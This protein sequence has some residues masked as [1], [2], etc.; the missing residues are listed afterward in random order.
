MRRFKEARRVSITLFWFLFEFWFSPSF[1]LVHNREIALGWPAWTPLCSTPAASR[2]RSDRR[3]ARASLRA[4]QRIYHP[5]FRTKFRFQQYCFFSWIRGCKSGTLNADEPLGS[6]KER[7]R[8]VFN[9]MFPL[10]DTLQI[11]SFPVV[12]LVSNQILFPP[13]SLNASLSIHGCTFG[14]LDG[15]LLLY[16]GRLSLEKGI[17]LLLDALM[18]PGVMARVCAFA[19]APSFRH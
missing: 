19:Q 9:P 12:D 4:Q 6:H 16:V 15:F 11:I 14:H 10:E 3:S 18:L 2:P 13:F 7:P 17:E 5:N 1:F 8:I